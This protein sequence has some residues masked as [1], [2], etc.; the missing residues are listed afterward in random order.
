MM[1]QKCINCVYCIQEKQDIYSCNYGY[2]NNYKKQEILLFIP[3]IFECPEF[4]DMRKNERLS[5]K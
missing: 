5:H 3:I 1:P 4:V 2:F